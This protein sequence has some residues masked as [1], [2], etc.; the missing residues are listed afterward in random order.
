M[1]EGS[2]CPNVHQSWFPTVFGR[3]RRVSPRHGPDARRPKAVIAL[4]SFSTGS[5]PSP[6]A[7]PGLRLARRAIGSLVV[8]VG[9]FGGDAGAS[10]SGPC[11]N[12]PRTRPCIID[13]ALQRVDWNNARFSVIEKPRR[14]VTF[15]PSAQVYSFRL[16]VHRAWLL[17][18][19]P[20]SARRVS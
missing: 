12:V 19:Y 11:A 20:P 6:R 4:D 17:S 18:G 14:D 1:G 3:R 15:R 10:E 7:L 5:V 16:I 8:C 13:E 9:A 2:T